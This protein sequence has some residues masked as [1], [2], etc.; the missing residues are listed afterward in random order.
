MWSCIRAIPC[1]IN[2]TL[3]SQWK[4]LKGYGYIGC[5]GEKYCATAES[6][7]VA[8]VLGTPAQ[9]AQ[10]LQCGSYGR[11]ISTLRLLRLGAE[12]GVHG[13]W[14]YILGASNDR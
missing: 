10:L 13:A 1:L 3:Q 5:A 2:G 4:W 8:V 6:E 14:S 9:P 12:Q 7:G 11:V